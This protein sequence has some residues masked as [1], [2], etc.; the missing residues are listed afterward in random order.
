MPDFAFFYTRRAKGGLAMRY[1]VIVRHGS[2]EGN[3]R[4]FFQGQRIDLP[5][6]EEG[7]TEMIITAD[8]FEAL[9][10]ELSLRICRIYVSPLM[11]AKES[12]WFLKHTTPD[13]FSRL[14]N[15]VTA[16]ADALKEID[17]GDWEGLNF[18]EIQERH[19]EIYADWVRD[20]AAFAFPNGETI[21]QAEKRVQTFA[22][23]L[24][25][26]IPSDQD[27]LLVTHA[28]IAMLLIKFYCR[29]DYLSVSL[30]NGGMA[31]IQFPDEHPHFMMQK[32][33]LVRIYA[34][35]QKNNP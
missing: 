4:N 20:T 19:P 6:T 29:T 5:L 26:T 23:T 12:L 22:T 31:L 21:A 35:K 30:A 16:D 9:C 1:C 2:T 10:E 15:V 3:E 17:Q 14:A 13:L 32:A 8:Q 11:R 18:Q 7:Y 33:R 24:A 34:P 28:G 25:Q 27:V